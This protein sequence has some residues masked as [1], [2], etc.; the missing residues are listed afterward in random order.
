MTDEEIM[1]KLSK[2]ENLIS[3]NNFFFGCNLAWRNYSRDIFQIF[4]IYL[5]GLRYYDKN[6]R[7]KI[8]EKQW[9]QFALRKSYE[10]D[11]SMSD[12]LK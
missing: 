2:S 5:L 3:D 1:A 11:V 10:L 12:P 6:L 4:K 7:G 9:S 8:L